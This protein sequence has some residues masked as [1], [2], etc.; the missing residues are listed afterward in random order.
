M[1]HFLKPTPL[2]RES[3]HSLTRQLADLL[4]LGLAELRQKYFELFGAPS[5]S[6]NLPFLRRKLAFRLQEHLEGG[7][8]SSAQ[9][10]LDALMPADLPTRPDQKG[11]TGL[12]GLAALQVSGVRPRDPRLP[13][14]GSR[15]TREYKGVLHSVEVLDS[16][17]R[18]QDHVYPS[19]SAVARAITGGSWNGFAFFHLDSEHPHGR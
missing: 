4:H 16:G 2:P 8:S 10:Q 11:S 15:I 12:R 9:A 13:A 14:L 3:L 18:Y 6:K 17:F 1:V 19:L 7:L 5:Q